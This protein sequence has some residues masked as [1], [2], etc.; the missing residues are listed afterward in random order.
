MLYEVITIPVKL[1]LPADIGVTLDV[2]EDGSTY[3][4][5]AQKKARAYCRASGLI[6][7]ADDSGL[8]VDAL[9]GAPGIHSARFAPQPGATDSYNFV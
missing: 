9:D 5:N 6:T 4:A 2:L 8:E 3:L 7:L 1:V